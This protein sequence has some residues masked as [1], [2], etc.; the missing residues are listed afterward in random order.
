MQP[1][2]KLEIIAALHD[3]HVKLC[4]HFQDIATNKFFTRKDGAWSPY[5]HVDHLIKSHQQVIRALKMPKVLLRVFFGMPNFPKKDY[6]GVSD[7]YLELEENG[8]TGA[9][10]RMRNKNISEAMKIKAIDQ[11]R[12]T[13]RNLI[14]AADPWSEEDLDNYI[15]KDSVVGVMRIREALFFTIFHNTQHLERGE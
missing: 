7:L 15:V 14:K 2:T 3:T 1:A 11:F 9:K 8:A 5:N 4:L 10:P 12:A 6:L 13:G